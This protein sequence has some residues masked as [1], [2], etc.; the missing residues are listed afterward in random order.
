MRRGAIHRPE[1]LDA[2]LDDLRDTAPE[3]ILITGDLT[4]VSLESEFPLA[5]EWLG[6]IGSPERVTLVPGNH[7]AYVRVARARS[8]DL[9]SGYLESDAAGR[10]L[11]SGGDDAKPGGLEF[12]S[13]RL[14]GPLAI[15]GL[16]SALPTP[17]FLAS[18]A[19]G[20]AQL[21][22][23]ERVLLELAASEYFRVVLIHHPPVPG[24]ATPRR[25]LRDA[26]ALCSVLRR[27]GADLVLHGH[28]HRTGLHSVPGRNGPIPVVGVRSASDFG[29]KPH[30]RAQYH[31][32]DVESDGRSGAR[33]RFRIA[34]RTRGYDAASGRFDAEGEVVPDLGLVA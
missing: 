4:N 1:V 9:W 16:S 33:P 11:L 31:L 26:E 18:G 8:W 5:R 15:V 3:Q 24:V 19:I 14:R 22:R 34:M 23:C 7:D 25:A 6:R 20:S 21:E 10:E 29:S 28:M 27:T 12:P 17:P 32:Y 2:M 13:V 30:K